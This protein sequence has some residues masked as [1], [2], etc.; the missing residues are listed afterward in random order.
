VIIRAEVQGDETGEDT[1][2]DSVV[3]MGRSSF[4]METVV[5]PFDDDGAPREVTGIV[6]SPYRARGAAAANDSWT[7][8][9]DDRTEIFAR[10]RTGQWRAPEPL[11]GSQTN[12]PLLAAPTGRSLARRRLRVSM[13]R[14]ALAAAGLL[15]FAFGLAL[16]AGARRA[17]SG[18]SRVAAAAPRPAR[19][20]PK[21]TPTVAIATTGTSSTTETS[22]TI[23]T[24][25]IALPEPI[26][27]RVHKKTAAVSTPR[28]GHAAPAA[29]RWVDP[30]AD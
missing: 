1:A 8:V 27:V 13:S 22:S 28:A 14:G 18:S 10:A 19:E 20:K 26:L 15:F 5:E 29:A 12:V 6:T 25:L 2:M 9:D 24:P 7:S 23:E 30:F 16:G 17:T 3:Y 11:F 4:R 21:P